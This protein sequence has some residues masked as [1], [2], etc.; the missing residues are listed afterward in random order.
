MKAL[1]FMYSLITLLLFNVGNVVEAGKVGV[2][3]DGPIYYIN[4]EKSQAAFQE[5]FDTLFAGSGHSV[6]PVEKTVWEA[7]L[8]RE[9]NGIAEIIT[10]ANGGE[11]SYKYR[12]NDDEV[13]AF[14]KQME[15][16]YV[17]YVHML[18]NRSEVA[19]MFSSGVKAS[20]VMT[21]KV[22]NI[23][24]NKYTGVSVVGGEV[25][26]NDTRNLR[27][28][29]GHSPTYKRAFNKAIESGLEK[30]NIKVER[31]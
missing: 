3:L 23:A 25:T 30:T 4:D 1:I 15:C 21:T 24:Q 26:N 17:V 7:Q 12:L 13:A 29:I 10:N 19:H 6:L 20:L 8:F 9:E 11:G 22:F 14:G 27:F 31:I 5:Y 28:P 2:V 16:D 18:G